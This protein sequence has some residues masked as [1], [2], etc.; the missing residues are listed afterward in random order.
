MKLNSLANLEGISE[1]ILRHLPAFRHV[2]DYFRIILWIEPKQGAVVRRHRV[3]HGERGF[4]VSVKRR[5]RPPDGKHKFAS[6]ARILFFS[7]K[8]VRDDAD[9]Q[10]YRD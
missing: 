6:C 1:R 5:W 7:G 2:T 8:N 9:K 4:A 3:K 10:R